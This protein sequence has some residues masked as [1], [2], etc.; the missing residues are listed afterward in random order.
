MNMEPIFPI[1]ALQ[2]KPAEVKAAAHK[3]VV[4]ITENGSAAYIFA[5]EE[6]YEKRIQEAVEDAVATA[7]MAYVIERG[8]AD[9]EAG[10]YIEGSDAAWAEVEKRA[11]LYAQD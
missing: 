4:R 10:R 9:F 3:D 6:V 1:T 5:T 11:A 7:R 8:R 2:K